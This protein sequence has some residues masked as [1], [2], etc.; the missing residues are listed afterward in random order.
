[1]SAEERQL[2]RACEEN[3]A[4]ADRGGRAGEVDHGAQEGAQQVAYRLPGVR[5]LHDELAALT[6]PVIGGVRQLEDD[7]ANRVSVVLGAATD[8]LTHLPTP[9]AAALDE[10]REQAGRV[11]AA[12]DLLAERRDEVTQLK[13]K[14][15]DL[16]LRVALADDEM[17]RLSDSLAKRRSELESR[18][19]RARSSAAALAAAEERTA[20]KQRAS[21]LKV[22]LDGMYL[23]LGGAGTRQS[24]PRAAAQEQVDGRRPFHPSDQSRGID[25]PGPPRGGDR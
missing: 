19:G 3:G 10:L 17:R 23:L 22:E 11:E 15:A 9:L 2:A 18:A 16:E 14:A 24:Q 6:G 20:P 12:K 5:R 7:V 4:A 13:A 1:M 21:G 25:R 8:V